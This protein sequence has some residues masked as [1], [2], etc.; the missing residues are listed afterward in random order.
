LP[1]PSAQPVAPTVA[2]TVARSAIGACADSCADRLRR[3]SPRVYAAL[4]ALCDDALFK[5][6]YF[7]FTFYH[8]LT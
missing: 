6:T 8:H 2:P 7:Y 4:E 3:R 5:S 1:Q